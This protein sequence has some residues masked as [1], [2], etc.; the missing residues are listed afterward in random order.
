MNQQ[1]VLASVD[2]LLVLLLCATPMLA[3]SQS[4]TA[5][6]CPSNQTAAA[7]S[8]TLAAE[9]P[10]RLSEQVASIATA[11]RYFRELFGR[12]PDSLAELKSKSD[13]IDYSVFSE[14]PK[15]AALPDD[16]AQLQ[17]FDGTSWREKKLTVS[18]TVKWQ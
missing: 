14:E 7:G 3:Q 6:V 4:P 17:V 12:W 8:P 15:L 11:S 10:R 1:K 16:T 2:A 9:A 13:G 5:S 18:S